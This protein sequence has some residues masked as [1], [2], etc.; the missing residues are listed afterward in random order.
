MHINDEFIL[1]DP[2]YCGLRARVPKFANKGTAEMS[3]LGPQY[4][5]HPQMSNGM[6]HSRSVDS[7]M[8]K[9]FTQGHLF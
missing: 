8:G 5:P 2:Y 4:Y 7:G 3:R 9:L 1:D 6:V